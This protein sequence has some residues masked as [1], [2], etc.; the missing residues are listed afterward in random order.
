MI[1]GYICGKASGSGDA[2]QDVQINVAALAET[3]GGR[4]THQRAGGLAGIWPYC[5]GR[6]LAQG[7]VQRPRSVT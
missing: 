5:G 6:A 4:G 1:A 3:A 2:E 7:G